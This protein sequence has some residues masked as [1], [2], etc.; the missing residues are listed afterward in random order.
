MI[1]IS[2]RRPCRI[3]TASPTADQLVRWQ[4]REGD[5]SDWA[6][7]E[8]EFKIFPRDDRTHVQFRHSGSRHEVEG[9]PYYATSWAVFLLSLRTFWKRE[10]APPIP[11]T[12]SINRSRS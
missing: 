9:I 11:T 2:A 12:G 5:L 6:G 4:A 3:G 1:S 10:R 7:T 8:I